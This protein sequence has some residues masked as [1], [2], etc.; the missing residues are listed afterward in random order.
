MA[1]KIVELGAHNRMTV[2]DVLGLS[3]REKPKMVVILFEDQEGNFGF[4]SSKME[5]RDALWMIKQ[6]ESWILP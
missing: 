5:N 6:A 3:L 2:D 1:E 4:R